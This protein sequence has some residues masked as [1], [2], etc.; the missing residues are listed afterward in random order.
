MPVS[1]TCSRDGCPPKNIQS[2]VTANC[3]HCKSIV[4][5]PC[6][7]I[8]VKMPQITSPNIRIYCNKCSNESPKTST[9]ST[10]PQI[11]SQSLFDCTG[12]KK[13]DELLILTREIHTSVNGANVSSPNGNKQSFASV[14][15]S[16]EEKT[17]KV[18]ET[19]DALKNQQ[20]MSKTPISA[21]RN[22]HRR[23]AKLI[24]YYTFTMHCIWHI[25]MQEVCHIRECV[26]FQSSL[27]QLEPTSFS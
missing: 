4:H 21:I 3:A 18:K 19:T 22:I 5:L 24:K 16:I 14:L 11:Q 13:L 8:L 15:K 26:Q 10:K 1:G 6:I 12:N 20:S 17:A 9:S 23:F 7:G 2:D 27:K 25:S